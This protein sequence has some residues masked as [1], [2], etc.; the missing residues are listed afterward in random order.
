MAS[1]AGPVPSQHLQRACTG[2]AK[3]RSP[4]LDVPLPSGTPWGRWLEELTCSKRCRPVLGG[5]SGTAGAWGQAG[6][7]LSPQQWKKR[8]ALLHDQG[9]DLSS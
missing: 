6:A 8:C 3:G 5:G 1:A 2:S 9:G 7:L 4:V